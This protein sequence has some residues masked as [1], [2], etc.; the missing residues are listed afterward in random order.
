MKMEFNLYEQYNLITPV[1]NNSDFGFPNT[2]RTAYFAISR[3]NFALKSLNNL[4]DVEFPK[5]ILR[6]AEMRFLRGHLHFLLKIL[7]KH[8]PYIDETL[9]DDDILKV[10]NRQYKDNEL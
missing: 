1:N 9:S 3:A 10:S 4:T 7:F 2:W 8:V 5:R 6:Q